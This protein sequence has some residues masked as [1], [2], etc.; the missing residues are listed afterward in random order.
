MAQAVGAGLWHMWHYHGVYGFHHPDPA[1][2]L[3]IRIRRMR[4][5]TPGVTSNHN[6]PMSWII[7]DQRGK[8]FMNEY[9]PHKRTPTNSSLFAHW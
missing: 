5:W 3:G 2:R 9:D 8:R 4:N 1:F 7:V 6:N